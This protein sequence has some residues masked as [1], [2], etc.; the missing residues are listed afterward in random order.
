MNR[1]SR[2]L[3]SPRNIA[4]CSLAMIGL[5]L[6]FVGVIETGW[7]LIVAGLYAVGALGWPRSAPAAPPQ[8]IEV[9]ADTLR[10]SGRC[11]DLFN[12]G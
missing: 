2:Y 3:Y 9:P 4:G 10:G 12:L 1:L 5:L 6:L 7:P 11:G 8:S